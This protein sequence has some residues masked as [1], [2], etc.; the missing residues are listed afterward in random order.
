MMGAKLRS[1]VQWGGLEPPEA[2]RAEDIALRGT[3]VGPLLA[4]LEDWLT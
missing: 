4:L 1:L 3:S 2:D